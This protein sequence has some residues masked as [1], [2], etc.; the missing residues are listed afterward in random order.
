MREAGVAA[1]PAPE[2]IHPATSTN[3]MVWL[4]LRVV[5]QKEAPQLAT[6]TAKMGTITNEN[7]PMTLVVQAKIEVVIGMIVGVEA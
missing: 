3:K 7:V 6:K 2:T 4:A 5:T 1:D